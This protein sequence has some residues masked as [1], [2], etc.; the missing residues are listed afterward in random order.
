MKKLV[1]IAAVICAFQFIMLN[2][3]YA[4]GDSAQIKK[5]VKIVFKTVQKKKYD[6]ASKQL[7]YEGMAEIVMKH[8]WKKMS[9]PDKAEMI[10][11][12][13][14]LN[15]KNSFP[16][17][18]DMFKHLSTVL[19]GK[20]RV[21]KDIGWCKVTVVVF[22][23]YKKKEIVIDFKLRKRSGKW[24]L[25]DIYMIGEGVLEGIYEDDVTVLVKEGGVQ[26]VMKALRES[27]A[28][29]KSK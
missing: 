8:H 7:D 3:L 2:H 15:R 27:V 25:I 20:P 4:A 9:K 19:Y 17:G 1:V 29:A 16:N 14:I 12:I 18:T 13:E 24:K 28:E 10:K 23:N 6:L 26:A 22:Q 21:K 5:T 11:G